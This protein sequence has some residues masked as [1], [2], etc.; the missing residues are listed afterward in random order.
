MSLKKISIIFLIIFI[1]S[2]NVVSADDSLTDLQNLIDNA[3]TLDLN[4]DFS[5]ENGDSSDG[6]YVSDKDIKINGNNHIIDGK[7]SSKLFVFEQCDVYIENLTLINGYSVEEYNF[8]KLG[9]AIDFFNS[10]ITLKNCKFINNHGTTGGAIY[11]DNSCLFIDN[12]SFINNAAL[13]GAAISLL[14]CSSNDVLI[15]NSIFNN[16]TCQ[17]NLEIEGPPEVDYSVGNTFLYCY[18]NLLDYQIFINPDVYDENDFNLTFVNVSYNDFKNKSF[19][20]K[21]KNDFD[22]YMVNK[23]IRFELYDGDT[24]L[25]NTTNV[26]DERGRANIDYDNI[27]PG[28]YTLNVYYMDLHDC[29]KIKAE[30]NSKL[31]I[32]VNNIT[33]GEDLVIHIDN[34]R[35]IFEYST[36]IVYF[37][38]PSS[39]VKIY[40]YNINLENTSSI[41]ISSLPMGDYKVGLFFVS[42]FFSHNSYKPLTIYKNFKVFPAQNSTGNETLI[43]SKDIYK[44][45]GGDEQLHINLTD[46]NGMPLANKNISININGRIYNRTTNASGQTS[47]TINLDA[48][49]YVV[50]ISFGGDDFYS[51]STTSVIIFIDSTIQTFDPMKKYVGESD[52]FVVYCR[53]SRGDYLTQGNVE[54]NINGVFYQRIIHEDGD[55]RLNINLA[56]GNYTIT[57]KNLQTGEMKSSLIII[58]PT[59]ANNYDL[60]KHY[61]NDSQFMVSV[62][63]LND[64]DPKVIF[65]INGVFYERK[66]N[67]S[68]IAKLNINL[69]PGEYIITSMYNGCMVSNNISVLPVLNTTNLKMTYLDGSTFNATLVDGQGKPLANA[70]VTFNINGVFYHRT[71]DANGIARLNIRLMAGEYIITSGYNGCNIANKITIV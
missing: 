16:N 50:F 24:L 68:G 21:S 47:M 25:I 4:N 46:E 60:T 5:F 55:A 31:S 71:T 66:V 12:S 70:D 48:G 26:T 43:S 23:T 10:S 35:N 42:E 27:T 13:N 40:E 18:D 57:A 36:I 14:Y 54:F 53:D 2:I 29:E 58:L 38:T 56:Q 1:L 62:E 20:V 3:E 63:T 61:K 9:G 33:V 22:E 49:R 44:Y 65:N 34:P 59:I 17:F 52:Q 28:Y 45:Y 39:S 37:E 51:P 7:N 64:K 30:L 15:S 41:N 19:K 11:S 67:D 69:E 8:D 6:V 32:S